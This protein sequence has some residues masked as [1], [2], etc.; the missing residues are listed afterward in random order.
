MWEW[1]VWNSI[2][3]YCHGKSGRDFTIMA[4]NYEK[5]DY[6]VKKYKIFKWIVENHNKHHLVENGKKLG[7]F[8]VTI[9][10]LIFYIILIINKF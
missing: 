9:Q 4:F 1:I 5:T 8:N 7:N 10:E 6:L 2:H 3:P